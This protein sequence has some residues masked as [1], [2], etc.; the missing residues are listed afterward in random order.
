LVTLPTF[1][2]A[3]PSIISFLAAS[4]A[5]LLIAACSLPALS[6]ANSMM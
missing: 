1:S 6:E 3:M 5:F 2:T 4:L